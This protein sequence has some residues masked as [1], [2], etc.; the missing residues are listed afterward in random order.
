MDFGKPTSATATG[1]A[2][3]SEGKHNPP[4]LRHAAV[5]HLPTTLRLY[6]EAKRSVCGFPKQS[7]SVSAGKLYAGNTGMKQALGQHDPTVF[8]LGLI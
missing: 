1:R 6:H 3:P 8:K 4:V 2:K 7:L 5:D